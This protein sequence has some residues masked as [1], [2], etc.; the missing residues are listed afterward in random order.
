MI[1]IV[2]LQEITTFIKIGT[3]MHTITNLP[4]M[5]ALDFIIS[6]LLKKPEKFKEFS[7]GS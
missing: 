4:T 2:I 6:K 7:D 3:A 1:Y 5:L